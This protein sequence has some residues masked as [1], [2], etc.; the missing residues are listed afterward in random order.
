LHAVLDPVLGDEGK[1]YVK[2]EVVDV[3]R[4]TLVPLATVCTP[5]AFEAELLTGIKVEDEVS[6]ML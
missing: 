6:E 3:M 4:E 1:C 5:N 2:Q